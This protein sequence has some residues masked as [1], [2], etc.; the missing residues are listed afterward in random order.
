MHYCAKHVPLQAVYLPIQL[1]VGEHS[2]ANCPLSLSLLY[3]WWFRSKLD[4]MVTYYKTKSKRLFIHESCTVFV[5]PKLYYAI[6]IKLRNC[7]LIILVHS[8]IICPNRST[9]NTVVDSYLCLKK[10]SHHNLSIIHQQESHLIYCVHRAWHSERVLQP[11]IFVSPGRNIIRIHIVLQSV[12][13][14]NTSGSSGKT[15][16]GDR[17]HL[18]LHYSYSR[19]SP[20]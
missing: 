10:R 15:K 17:I 8:R 3:I 7:N 20:S 19:H 16:D 6:C 11:H 2:P 18:R 13:R 1:V 12:V 5:R 9:W 4:L 14:N